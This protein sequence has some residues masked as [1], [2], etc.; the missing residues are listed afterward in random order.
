VTA[1]LSEAAIPLSDTAIRPGSL[2][3]V[4]AALGE[5]E[6]PEGDLDAIHLGHLDI[7]RTNAKVPPVRAAD[8]TALALSLVSDILGDIGFY[9]LSE[10]QR[11]EMLADA[12]AILAQTVR[13]L[14][15]EH[16]AAPLRST[17][18]VDPGQLPK[19]AA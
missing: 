5:I 19:V 13:W 14:M 4:A 2:S 6:P 15:V 1:K 10:E 17:W 12:S 16:G 11:E 8:D 3:S 18:P 7:L 9:E